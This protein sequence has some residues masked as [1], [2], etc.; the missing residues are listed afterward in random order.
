MSFFQIITN[1]SCNLRCTYCY[2]HLDHRQNDYETIV[3][4]LNYYLENDDKKEEQLTIDFIGGEPFMVPHLLRQTM[5]YVL[6]IY[7]KYG[8]QSV[9]F[10][11]STN[12]TLINKPLQKAIIEDYKD[13]IKVGV[14]IDGVAEHHD[15]CRLTIGGKGSHHLTLQGYNTLIDILGKER[16]Y[17]KSTFTKDNISYLAKSLKYTASLKPCQRVDFNFNFEEKLDEYDGLLIANELFNVVE[18]LNSNDNLSGMAFI[19][20]RYRSQ[21]TQFPIYQHRTVRPL[22]TNRCGSCQHMASIGYDGKVY[23]CNRFLTMAKENTELAIFKNNQ[24]IKRNDFK[25][26]MLKAY[27]SLPNDCQTC[28]FNRDCK[29]C[30][31]VA[32]DEDITFKDYYKERRMCGQT[33]AIEVAKLYNEL[34]HLTRIKKENNGTNN[35]HHE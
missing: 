16:V 30:F 34:L 5:D 9:V 10:S 6:S 24:I 29:D 23:G 11:F 7:R 2:E 33:K 4:I 31:A 35:R 17:V 28:R 14:S 12:A 15:K 3:K 25:E 21:I 22:N 32:I 13:Y 26:N 19:E 8:Y 18:Y 1:T 20:P 27:Q